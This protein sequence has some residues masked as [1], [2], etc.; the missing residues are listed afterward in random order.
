MEHIYDV[1]IIGGGPAGYSAALYG[2]RAGLDVLLLEKMTAGGQMTLTG[3]IENYPGIDE[4]VDGFTLGEKMKRAAEKFG[5]VTRFAEVVSVEAEGKVKAAHTRS[6]TLYGRTLIIAAGADPR[7]LGIEREDELV[8]RGVHYCAHCDGRFYKDKTVVVVGGGNSAAEDALYLSGLARKVILVHRRDKLRA[9]RIYADAL[10]RA[11]NVEFKWDHQLTG[12]IGERG[13]TGARI[14]SI[15]DGVEGELECDGVFISVGREPSSA[16]LGDAVPLDEAGYVK[17]DETT[18]T[19]VDG[20]FAAGDIRTK[21]LR[22]IV[23]AAADGAVAI[24]YV[25]KYL[26]GG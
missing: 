23:T 19:A 22:Q 26:Y 8:G 15:T 5:A 10:E 3:D 2:A 12:F 13:V 7:R 20:V 24:H 16:F 11:E 4:A 25:E 14:R 21:E 9:T 18:R 6:E 17:A 1:L